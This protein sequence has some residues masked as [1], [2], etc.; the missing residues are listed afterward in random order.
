MF[1]DREKTN[2]QENMNKTEQS[3][4]YDGVL[5]TY[6]PDH[7]AAM[8]LH[9]RCCCIYVSY[10]FRTPQSLSNSTRPRP[11]DISRSALLPN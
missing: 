9:A 10:R 2:W 5:T 7:T 4:N 1:N 11:I 3:F 6:E 8:F